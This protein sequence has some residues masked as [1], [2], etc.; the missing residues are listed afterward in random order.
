MS[1]PRLDVLSMLN[2]VAKENAPTYYTDPIK[3]ICNV[4]KPKHLKITFD[5]SIH[6]TKHAYLRKSRLV[7]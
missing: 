7:V 4:Q 1:D 3:K 6:H 2:L 5:R